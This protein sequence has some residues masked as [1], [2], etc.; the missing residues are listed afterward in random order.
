MWELRCGKGVVWGSWD[1]VELRGVAVC[2][3][4]SVGGEFRCE[5]VAELGRFGVLQTQFVD[6]HCSLRLWPFMFSAFFAQRINF[7]SKNLPW[8]YHLTQLVLL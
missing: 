7:F 6:T 2:G 8:L 4:C 1:L 3:S 5:G